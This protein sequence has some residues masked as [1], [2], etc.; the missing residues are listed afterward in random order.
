MAKVLNLRRE[1]KRRARNRARETGDA[2]AAR[3]GRSGAEKRAEAAE[4]ERVRRELEGH[5]LDDDDA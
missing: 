2:N 1:K 3:H 4:R 5:R